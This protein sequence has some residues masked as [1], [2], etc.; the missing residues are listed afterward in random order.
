MDSIN[1]KLDT[2]TGVQ[3]STGTTDVYNVGHSGH[4][5]FLNILYRN[6]EKYSKIV[7]KEKEK[8]KENNRANYYVQCVQSSG[9]PNLKTDNASTYNTDNP[10]HST[11]TQ[12]FTVS[13]AQ[14]LPNLPDKRFKSPEFRDAVR[15]V[16]QYF[17]YENPTFKD[18]R[19][20]EDKFRLRDGRVALDWLEFARRILN[21]RYEAVV[22]VLDGLGRRVVNSRGYVC[23]GL[24]LYGRTRVEALC[25]LDCRLYEFAYWFDLGP[26]R[27]HQDS[28]GRIISGGGYQRY[29]PGSKVPQNS[30]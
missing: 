30:F 16:L 19:E 7:G 24:E 12:K 1:T 4:S 13:N 18:F 25:G 17:G 20:A 3:L 29:P 9:N 5:N 23:R 21:P 28:P 8:Y 27:T 15:V 10:G 26:H 14:N 6:R 22:Y 2:N 11:K